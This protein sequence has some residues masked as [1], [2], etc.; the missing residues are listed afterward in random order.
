MQRKRIQR[1]RVFWKETVARSLFRFGNQGKR[2]SRQ[3]G[4]VQRLANVTWRIGTAGVM[5]ETRSAG[6]EIQQRGAG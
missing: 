3:R 1:C 2:D 4:H 6:K 5:V